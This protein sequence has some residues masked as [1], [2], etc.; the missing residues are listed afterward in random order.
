[1][2]QRNAVR[3]VLSLSLLG[4]LVTGCNRE[5]S[6]TTTSTPAPQTTE[7]QQAAAPQQQQAP[8]QMTPPAAGGQAGAPGGMQ[9]MPPL[10]GNMARPDPN[11]KVS[12]TLP[13]GWTQD[14]T[15]RPMRYATFKAGEGA[16]AAEIAVTQFPGDVGGLRRNVDRWRDQIGLPAVTDEQLATEVQPFSSPGF[17]GHTMRLRGPQQHMLGA[18][19]FEEAANRTWFVKMTGSPEAADKHEAEFFAFAKSFGQAK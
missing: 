18:A 7:S 4:G 6:T 2:S 19:I 14:P 3:T 13:A 8:Q 11:A 12:W 1:M 10:S 15:Q 9:A 5:E 16:T 17:K